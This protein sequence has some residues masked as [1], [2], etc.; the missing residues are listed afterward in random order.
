MT[1][2]YAILLWSLQDSQHPSASTEGWHGPIMK[3]MDE[4]PR[5]AVST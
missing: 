3:T 2:A 1:L 4:Y 5:K